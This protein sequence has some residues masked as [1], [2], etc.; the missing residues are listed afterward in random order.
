MSEV[1]KDQNQQYSPI[2]PVPGQNEDSKA[3]VADLNL[4]NSRPKNFFTYV[5]NLFLIR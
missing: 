4:N 3:A 1:K 2:T 5:K